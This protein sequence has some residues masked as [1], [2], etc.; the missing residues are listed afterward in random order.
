MNIRYATACSGIEAPSV[1]WEPLGW[2]PVA[3]SEVDPFCSKLLQERHPSVPNLG[4]MTE[5]YWGLLEGSAD[6]FIAGTPCQSFSVA[7]LRE[8]L[9]DARGNLT[10]EYIRVIDRLKPRIAIWENVPGVLSTKDNAFGCFLAGLV[11]SFT[12]LF[13]N[14][15]AARA[16]GSEGVEPRRNAKWPGAGIVHGPRRNAAWRTLDA[17]HFGVAQRRRRVFVV[18]T[19]AR[20]PIHPGAILFEPESGRRDS[21]PSRKAG[22]DVTGTLGSRAS[23][24]GGF[25]SD[26]ECAGGLVSEGGVKG[27]HWDDPLNPHPTLNQSNNI[28][29]VGGSDQELFSQRGAYLTAAFGENNTSGPIDVATACTSNPSQRYDFESETLIAHTLRGDGFDASEDGTGRGFGAND[30]RIDIGL[31]VCPTVRPG[32]GG[33]QMSIGVAFRRGGVRRLTPRE[34]ERLQGFPDDYTRINSHRKRKRMKP[35][36]LTLFSEYRGISVDELKVFGYTPDG[37]RYKAIGNSMAVP[38]IRWI[39]RRIEKCMEAFG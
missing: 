28:G 12:E 29:G 9:D 37:P 10:L 8:S 31:G 25:S 24:G 4:D 11:G 33:G 36:E 19:D 22:Q 18:V 38:V 6:V 20:D 30:S 15:A 26:F 27:S 1:A 3:F 14:G 7:G 39:G 2:K 23:S 13:P 21:P 34:T 17:Q 35:E 5:A 32:N 16:A